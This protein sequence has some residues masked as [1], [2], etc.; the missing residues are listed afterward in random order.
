[1]LVA[2]WILLLV[3]WVFIQYRLVREDT[4]NLPGCKGY[5]VLYSIVEREPPC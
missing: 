5:T 2:L 4:R 3:G 1:M